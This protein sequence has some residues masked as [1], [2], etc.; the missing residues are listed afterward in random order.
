MEL[1]KLLENNS[2]IIVQDVES[3]LKSFTSGYFTNPKILSEIK[4]KLR[5]MKQIGKE[6]V[7]GKLYAGGGNYVIKTMNVCA[8]T[9]NRAINEMCES[10]KTGDLI[11]RVPNSTNNK[12]DVYAPIY[13]TEIIISVLLSNL[14]LYTDSFAHTYGVA[15]DRNS[16][17]RPVYM[18]MEK[19]IPLEPFVHEYSITYIIFQLVYGI[20]TAQ[21]AMRY[22]HF[23]LHDGNIMARKSKNI[24]KNYKIGDLYVHTK[25]DFE[26]VIIDYGANRVE[27]KNYQLIPNDIT[28]KHDGAHFLD[29]RQFNPYFDVYCILNVLYRKYPNGLLGEFMRELFSMFLGVQDGETLGY[30]IDYYKKWEWMP[31]PAK[32]LLRPPMKPSRFLMEIALV[33]QQHP[34]VPINENMFSSKKLIA[35]VGKE[36][37]YP[38]VPKPLNTDVKR[39]STS[40]SSDKFGPVSIFTKKWPLIYQTGSKTITVHITKID[41]SY[42]SKK[43]EFVFG[44]CDIDPKEQLQHRIGV[45]IN[46][47]PD[48]ERH[49]PPGL[50]KS[51]GIFRDIPLPAYKTNDYGWITIKDG[52][53]DMVNRPI[54]KDSDAIPMDVDDSRKYFSVS[55][56]DS[57]ITA[58]PVLVYG[59]YIFKKP[60]MEFL[61]KKNKYP[62]NNDRIA[63]T[64]LAINSRGE[65]FFIFIQ[66]P[67]NKYEEGTTMEELANFCQNE[68]QA[69]KAINLTNYKQSQMVWRNEKT[70]VIRVMDKNFIHKRSVG[71]TISILRKR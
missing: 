15:Y 19:L 32:L 68:L 48:D 21:K 34:G 50:Y 12:M 23:D 29:Q 1:A 45:S 28:G 60:Q 46:G 41:R 5:T 65:I 10:S 7:Y 64:A 3:F 55:D 24:S 38:A 66:G 13:L 9:N 33:I 39:I 47:S 70:D 14:R 25:Y 56:Y 59:N 36:N 53:L 18:V 30:W 57:I 49:N 37:L 51:K 4:T 62:T 22:V 27:T 58:G 2:K 40:T 52:V 11:F 16:S 54:P 20:F 69:V 67:T 71:T 8:K 17:I 35:P 44:C 43:Y 42:Y 61:Q 26:P 6:S 63:R 31:D